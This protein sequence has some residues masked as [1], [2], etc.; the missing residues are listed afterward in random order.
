MW[1]C[2][3]PTYPKCVCISA[4]IISKHGIGAFRIWN[5]NR[6]SQDATKGV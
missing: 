4:G 3:F 6:S 5:Y 2:T 1:S